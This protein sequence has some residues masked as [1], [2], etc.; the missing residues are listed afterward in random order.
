MLVILYSFW[1]FLLIIVY[2]RCFKTSFTGC[3][4]VRRCK[5]FSAEDDKMWSS[6]S[7]GRMWSFDALFPE[8]QW[9]EEIVK[10]DLYGISERDDLLISSKTGQGK[11]ITN[12]EVKN[13]D[14]M[15][16]K[17]VEVDGQIV[18]NINEEININATVDKEGNETIDHTLTQMVEERIY[19]TRLT[20]EGTY[21]TDNSLLDRDSA[22]QFRDG[23]RLGNPLKVNADK[24]TYYAKKELSRNKLD[25]AYDLYERAIKIDPKDGRA[26]LG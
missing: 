18:S 24:L 14:D 10:K 20:D 2:V 6:G 5:L 1:C 25:E 8:P 21:V 11:N 15:R 9:D 13:D 7:S 17:S 16:N 19:E 23:V 4:F 22:V 3:S 26:Y 12:K